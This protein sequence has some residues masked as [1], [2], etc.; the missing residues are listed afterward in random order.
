[1]STEEEIKTAIKSYIARNKGAYS[2]WY[3]GVSED[4]RDR[5]FNGHGVHENGDA[6]ILRTAQTSSIART[7]EQHFL[8]L[9]TDGGPGGGDDNAKSVYAYKKNSHTRP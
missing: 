6:W 4:A 8:D 2:A 7:I 3:V 5:L 9:G 1:M